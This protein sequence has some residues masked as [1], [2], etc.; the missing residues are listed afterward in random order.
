MVTPGNLLRSLGFSGDGSEI[1][2]S[3]SGNPGGQKVLMPLTSGAPR[4]FLPG[5]IDSILVA[6]DARLVGIGADK[7]GDPSLSPTGLART[8]CAS[9]A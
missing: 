9:R 7:S 6:S 2:F 5:T 8:R 1:W 4:P 3:R